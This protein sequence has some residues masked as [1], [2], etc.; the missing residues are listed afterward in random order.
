MI[1]ENKAAFKVSLP[2]KAL[3]MLQYLRPSSV[4]Y[5]CLCDCCNRV[6]AKKHVKK[7][8]ARE[9]AELAKAWNLLDPLGQGIVLL[10]VM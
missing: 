2:K 3:Q 1:Y 9:R 4:V 6:F 10:I 5:K 8:R 7:E